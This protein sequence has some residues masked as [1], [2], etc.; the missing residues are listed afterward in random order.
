MRNPVR[1]SKN[2]GRTQGGRVADGK[3]SEKWS[4]LWF[5]G[6]RYFKLSEESG[7]IRL[8][9]DNPSKNYY[10]PC[11]LDEYVKLLRLLPSW[12]CDELKAIILPRLSTQDEMRGVEARRIADCIILNPFPKSRELLW[13]S[14][15]PRWMHRHNE[16]WCERPILRRGQV[17]IQK[18]GP[19]EV[20]RYYLFHLFLHELGHI[21]QPWFHSLA[22]RE[23]F[24]E[25][26]ALEWAVKL[27]GLKDPTMGRSDF[28]RIKVGDE[29]GFDW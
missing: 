15:P 10:H 18:W 16:A 2:I 17:W 25:N 28:S 7:P 20:R 29:P 23:E 19:E 22:R 14:P 11:E 21:N 9:R 12:V 24:A 13:H 1:R 27:G 6:D 26:F 8:V 5:V 4:R 3:A